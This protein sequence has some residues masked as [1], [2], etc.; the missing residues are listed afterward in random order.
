M[1]DSMGQEF[2]GEAEVVF[3]CIRST[4]N[5][6]L[7]VGYDLQLSDIAVRVSLGF[8]WASV[9]RLLHR[10]RLEETHCCRHIRRSQDLDNTSNHGQNASN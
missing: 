4:T 8:L 3:L 10:F 5:I 7:H 1:F 6:V 9:A 2:A